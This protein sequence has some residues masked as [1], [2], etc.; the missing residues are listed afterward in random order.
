MPPS[1]NALGVSAMTV[2]GVRRISSELC[3]VLH[4]SSIPQ[5]NGLAGESGVHETG[6]AAYQALDRDELDR[7]YEDIAELEPEDYKTLNFRPKSSLHHY[8]LALAFIVYLI[9]FLSKSLMRAKSKDARR[10][11]DV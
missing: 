6:G 8:P 7:I 2:N 9:Y 11:N 10:A 4:R 1:G 3:A 5:R